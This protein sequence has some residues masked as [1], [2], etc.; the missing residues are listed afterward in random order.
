MDELKTLGH[1]ALTKKL[2]G[3]E[4]KKCG[5]PFETFGH[6]E[7]HACRPIL[8]LIWASVYHVWRNSFLQLQEVGRSQLEFG[9][10][11]RISLFDGP[12]LSYLAQRHNTGQLRSGSCFAALT[13]S[14]S[15]FS[16]LV[17]LDTV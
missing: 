1:P 3:R 13:P 6:L 11:D 17:P 12:E 8:L 7:S 10:V 5:W 4:K 15:A 16:A 2:A 14:I 9:Y